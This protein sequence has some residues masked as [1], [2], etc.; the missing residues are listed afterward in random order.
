MTEFRENGCHLIENGQRIA[1]RISG[2]HPSS[3]GLHPVVYFYSSTGRYQPTA[4]LATVE[5]VKDLERQNAFKEF[6]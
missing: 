2:L 4:F 3:L 1:N 6:A 5:M